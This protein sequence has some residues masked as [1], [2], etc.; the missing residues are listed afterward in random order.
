MQRRN[1]QPHYQEEAEEA[2]EH[3][4]ERSALPSSESEGEDLIDNAEAD[5]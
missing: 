4:S 5:Y 3:L 2:N 1:L